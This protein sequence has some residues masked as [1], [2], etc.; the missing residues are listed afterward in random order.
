MS[1]GRQ[2]FVVAVILATFGAVAVAGG[3]ALTPGDSPAESP[4][5]SAPTTDE[6]G[7]TETQSESESEQAVRVV[8]E[9]AATPPADYEDPNGNTSDTLGWAGGY[10]YDEPLPVNTSD[11]LNSSEVEMMS[12]RAAARVEALRCL[13]TKDGVPP[14]EILSREQFRENQSSL[15]DVS[16][17]RR[18]A[19]NAAL[20]IRL[21]SETE[22]DSTEEREQNRGATVGG[23]Y[24]FVTKEIVIVSDDPERLSID[25]AVLAHEIGHA[26]QDQHFDLGQYR[27]DTF[28]RDKAIL[29]LIEGDV[30][31]IEQQYRRACTN[32]GWEK[33]C[34]TPRSEGGGSGSG[35]SS[36]P[37]N[38]GLY[39]QTIQPYNDGPAFINYIYETG[40]GWESVNELYDNPPTSALEVIRPERYPDFEVANVTVPDRSSADFERYDGSYGPGYDRIG[41]AGVSAMFIAPTIESGGAV[42]IYEPEAFRARGSLRTYQYYQPETAG[43][44]GDRLYTYQ[45]P[46]N[47]TGAVWTTEWASPEEW[48]PFVAGYEQ[49][50]AFRGGEEVTDRTYE[51]DPE[52]GYDMALEIRTDG[53]QVTIVTAPTVEQLDAVHAEAPS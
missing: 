39:F 49:L 50:I 47:E 53:S 13:P 28:D 35:S 4:A 10:W 12:A 18:L 44:R 3:P 1:N 20:A 36:S 34:L 16:Q 43:W 41:I 8:D 14:V 27:R 30:H 48:E 15:F 22:T 21:L 40:N 19:D 38:W 26:I 23:T 11:G 17:E 52:S 7:G 46:A 45:G 9:C 24:N 33:G 25:E 29:G 31:Y 51:F 32:G 2:L 42:T 37:A 6:P 5:S